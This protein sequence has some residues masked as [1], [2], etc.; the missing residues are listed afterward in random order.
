MNIINNI[1]FQFPKT[2]VFGPKCLEQLATDYLQ[3][4]LS[5]LYLITVPE[6][7]AQLAPL[8]DALKSRNIEIKTNLNIKHEPSFT[9]FANLISEAKDFK[10]DSVMGIG[11]GSVMDVA[12]LVAVFIDSSQNIKEVIGNGL[13]TGRKTWLACVPTTSGTGSEV[14]PNAIMLDETDYS[15]KGIISKYLVPDCAYIDPML[16]VSVPP[17][18]TAFTGMDALAHCIEA[19][20]NRFAHVVA[21]TYAI[22]GT[23][24]IGQYLKQAF[25]NGNDTEARSYVAL[26]SVY[27][28]MCLGP[29]NTTAVHALAYP[30]GS[31]YKIP[32]GL[33]N[34]IILPFVMEFNIPNAIERYANV[35]LALGAPQG[36]TSKET[37][38]NGVSYIRDLIS[39]FKMPSRLSEVGIKKE[40]IQH[41]AEE[42]MKVQR[43]LKNNIRE[44]TLSDAL[45]IY[46][47]AF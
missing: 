6:V 31:E 37:A 41:I 27:G 23:R 13:I 21:D 9:D 38:L 36:K 24:L 45:E 15:K 1:T 29:V 8:T 4:G 43:L 19:Y 2:L 26:G 40:D 33:S 46:N 25:D 12:K 10:A 47:S 28:G 22:E 44:V 5:R 11:G 30:L 35:A 39:Y 34:A 16:T 42:G 14:S 32:H 20:T 17:V 18:V 3:L 7:L